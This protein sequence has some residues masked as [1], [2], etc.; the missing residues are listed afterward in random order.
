MT[1]PTDLTHI[2]SFLDEIR[3]EAALEWA[4]ERTRATDEHLA[5]SEHERVVARIQEAM[6]AQDR[7]ITVSRHGEFHTNFWQDAEH[8]RGIWR[9]TDWDSYVA[10]TPRWETLLDLDELSADEG[11]NWVWRGASWE[12]KPGGQP[13]RALVVL[14]PDGGDA[15]VVCEFDAVDRMFV[16][17]GLE[18][19]LAKTSVSWGFGDTF[20]VSTVTGDDDMTRSTYARC[21][22]RVRR[23][24]DLADAELLFE[25]DASHVAA[26]AGVDTTPGFEKTVFRDAEDFFTGTN[27]VA[28]GDGAGD[29]ADGGAGGGT[30]VGV[31][32]QKIDAP[33]DAHVGFFE[34]WLII[35]PMSTWEVNGQSYPAGT[36]LV[37][38]T[39]EWLAGERSGLRA[40]LVPEQSESV[41]GVG[42]TKNFGFAL[43]MRDVASRVVRLDPRNDWQVTELPGVPALSSVS[44]W[45]LDEE[46]SDDVWMVSEG[47]LQPPTLQLGSLASVSGAGGEGDGDD[48]SGGGGWRVIG[49]APERFD[50][51][52]HEVSQHFAVSDDGAR[53]PYFLVAPKDAPLDG[54][55]PV[56]VS[57]YGGFRVSRTPVY[58][59]AVG[60]G[61]LERRTD[62]GRAPA[63]VV[64]NIRGGGEYG[65]DWHAAA[66]RE[67]RPRAYEDLAAVVRDLHERGVS[68]AALT[69]M[70]GGS[71]GGLL[72]GNMYVRYPELFGAI[73]CGVPLLDMLRYTQLSAGHSWIAEY[74]DPDVPGDVEHLRDISATHRLADT[75]NSEGEVTWPELLVWTTASDDRV[76]PVQ[77]RHFYALLEEL[78]HRNA[79]YHEEV[80]G[81]HSG[82]VDHASAARTAA[83]SYSFIWGALTRQ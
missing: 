10:G 44:M 71:N 34:D 76:G 50:V 14:S 31:T 42:F 29:G 24:Q 16:E 15:V 81:G 4:A 17:G 40:V 41:Q 58:S 83:R 27:Y 55:T 46:N 11:V 2:H 30:G 35:R 65:P 75:A 37:V 36:V 33:G 51:S 45:P 38:K 23:G 69:G 25:V 62:E 20:L 59:S 52:A 22:R 63:F 78:G 48:G 21:V 13:R 28:L 32:V 3:G 70:A 12:P 47:F 61:W 43:I 8:P 68:S 57:A 79:W 9:T 56:Y 19:P 26:G 53:V 77:A 80:D 74:G 49:V 18:L 66:L 7:L 67:K 73:S 64:A 6:D 1:K 60:L 39:T 82:S 54:K 5:S 72:A